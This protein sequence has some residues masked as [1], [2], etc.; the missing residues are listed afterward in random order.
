MGPRALADEPDAVLEQEVGIPDLQD[1]VI[2]VCGIGEVRAPLRLRTR[3][4]CI[5]D[6]RHDSDPFATRAVVGCSP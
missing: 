4:P 1:R 5:R 3:L 6:R 2:R